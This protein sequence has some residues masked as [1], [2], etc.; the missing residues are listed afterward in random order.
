ML[1]E[2]RK[3]NNQFVVKNMPK[4]KEG[5]FYIKIN[6]KD[7]LNKKPKQQLKKKDGVL[8]QLKAL[9]EKFPNDVLIQN[10]IVFYKPHN[11][12]KIV[13]I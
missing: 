4:M 8:E 7:I 2:I 11:N 6:K 12:N 9:G 10:M 1:L 13:T 5:N 3:I